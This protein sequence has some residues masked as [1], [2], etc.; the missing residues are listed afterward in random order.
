MTDRDLTPAEEERVRRLLADAGPAGPMPPEVAARLE[1]VLADLAISQ[2]V[3]TGAAAGAPDAEPATAP[4]VDLARRRRRRRVGS[5]LVAAAAVTVIGVGL[6]TALRGGLGTTSSD[7]SGGSVAREATVD[8][9]AAN[10]GRDGLVDG[11]DRETED[12]DPA[13]PTDA[14]R[15]APPVRSDRFRR[16]AVRLARAGEVSE[17]S[18]TLLAD[19]AGVE[20]WGEGERVPATYDGKLGALVYRAPEEGWQ[21]VDLF[22]CGVTGV[23]RSTLLPLP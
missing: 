11:G 8:E 9:D 14:A 17:L 18:D 19:C 12:S 20:E 21:R 5:V 16:D 2:P 6:P 13:A 1:G 3:P 4:V 22:L 23:V 10:S 15:E 7:D